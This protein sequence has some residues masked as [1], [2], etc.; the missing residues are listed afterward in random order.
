MTDEPAEPIKRRLKSGR[1]PEK[2]LSAKAV[3]NA[4]P[5]RH[6][7]GNG[8][9]LVVDTTGAKRWLLRVVIKR[10]RCDIGLGSAALVPLAEAR[11]KALAYR[12]IARQGG[13][14]LFDD[15]KK[16]AIIPTF[17]EA[18]ELVHN[19]RKAGYKNQK[20]AAQWI[21]T[22]K[23]YAFPFIGDLPINIVGTPDVL[24]V[25]FPIWTSKEETAR[26]VAQRI[27]VVFDW[28]KAAG[29]RTG[30]NPVEGA[31]HGLQKQK[32]RKGH[33]AAMP[34]KDV[35]AFV[36][37][38][39]ESNGNAASHIPLEF[40]IL[41]AARTNEVLG[42]LWSEID[43]EGSTWTIPSERMKAEREHRVPLV[44]RAIAL[45]DQ[46]RLMSPTSNF[47]FVGRN[48][49]R[50]PSNMTLLE[51]L[52]RAKLPYTTHGFRSSFR[53]WAG[54]TTAHPADVCEM[55]LA[56]TIKNK[57]EAAYRRGDMF[58]RRRALMA[59]WANFLETGKLL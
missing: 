39:R 22:L 46:A 8:L 6:T 33:H 2:A 11:E 17:K 58:E 47:I 57:T 1:H 18:A 16:R 3:Q 20:H 54:E 4:K 5:G 51:V 29:H 49:E 52:K 59:D 19:D 35:P 14:P 48:V 10:K 40:L 21:S 23:M 41:T 55:A 53:D 9:Y 31:K 32:A 28:A 13:D 37:A 12:K 24:K 36:K 38:L 42:A 30:D 34:F 44:A 15:K 45:L 7:D 26:R 27:E 25:L 50:P 56:H 43:I